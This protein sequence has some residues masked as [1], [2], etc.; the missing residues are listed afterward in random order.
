MSLVKGLTLPVNGGKRNIGVTHMKGIPEL[1]NRLKTDCDD[2]ILLMQVGNL[3]VL[4]DG[5]AEEIARCCQVKLMP[6]CSMDNQVTRAEIPL[7]AMNK[8]VGK[9]LLSGHKV[10]IAL[11]TG[12]IFLLS[13]DRPMDATK[14]CG[15][16]QTKVEIASYRS[17]GGIYGQ[18]QPCYHRLESL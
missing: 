13:N 9:L 17:P 10:A 5:D 1:Y 8:Y 3:L 15:R 16:S 11:Q 12:T 4:F 18:G 6:G 7:V 14:R 2:Y